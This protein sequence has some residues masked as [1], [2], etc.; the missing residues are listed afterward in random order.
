[1]TSRLKIRYSICALIMIAGIVLMICGMNFYRALYLI[2]FGV[3]GLLDRI[4]DSQHKE[5]A[6]GVE[7]WWRKVLANI[8]AIFLTFSLC[9]FIMQTFM[10]SII[11]VIIWM[12]ICL[13]CGMLFGTFDYFAHNTG[14]NN[15]EFEARKQHEQKYSELYDMVAEE[16]NSTD[17]DDIAG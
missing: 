16:M 4:Y 5:T 15:D 12:C 17:R 10:D 3:F 14:E 13:L 2:L 1:M 9:N 8:V 6:E 11:D 7:F